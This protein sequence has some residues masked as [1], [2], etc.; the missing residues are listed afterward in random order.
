MERNRFD[1]FPRNKVTGIY[2][3]VFKYILFWFIECLQ[4]RSTAV[5]PSQAE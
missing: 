3:S 2:Q 4:L 1:T 5:D